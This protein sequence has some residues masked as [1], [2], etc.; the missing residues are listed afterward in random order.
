MF[1]T[2]RTIRHPLFFEMTLKD[3]SQSSTQ[4]ATHSYTIIATHTSSAFH[5]KWKMLNSSKYWKDSLF[6]LLNLVLI[7]RRLLTQMLIVTCN[8][9][10]A[11]REF[12]SK[13]VIWCAQSKEDTS[14]SNENESFIVS[15]LD[16]KGVYNETRNL[17][18]CSKSWSKR[19]LLICYWLLDLSQTM[20]AKTRAA[21][22]QMVVINLCNF[23]TLIFF[24]LF[25]NLK[26]NSVLYH[27]QIEAILT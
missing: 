24:F 7:S 6:K 8:V 26:Q 22:V 15:W 19:R 25:L 27:D 2:N 11:N 23:R 20:Y 14:F 17:A 10:L 12:M 5:Q 3:I 21:R 18:Y 13:L 1:I 9:I 4:L 16:V